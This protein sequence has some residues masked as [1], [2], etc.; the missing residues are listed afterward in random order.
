MFTD[1][2]YNDQID[3]YVSGFGKVHHREFAMAS[4]EMSEAEFT[5]FLLKTFR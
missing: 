5:E 3:G 1:P 4:G 2:P